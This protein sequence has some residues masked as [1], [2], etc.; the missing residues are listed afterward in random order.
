MNLRRHKIPPPYI[1]FISLADIAWQIIIF[2]LIASTFLKSD[3]LSLIMPGGGS[4]EQSTAAPVARPITLRATELALSLNGQELALDDLQP[5]IA[6][7]L[8]TAQTEEDRVIVV[9]P[10]D[11]LSFQRNADIFYAV[12]KA[13]G[14]VLISPEASHAAPNPTP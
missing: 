8:A 9:R 13:G 12:Q 10:G 3:V 4:E 7:L 5:R 11:D 14:T 1:P 6:A 2:F